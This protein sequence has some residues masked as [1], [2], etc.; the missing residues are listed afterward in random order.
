MTAEIITIGDE[1]LIGQIVDTN[2]A[3]ISEK[4][5]AIGVRVGEI[6]SVSDNRAHILDTLKQASLRADILILTGGLGPTKDDITKHILA[7][8]TGAKDWVL[9]QPSL[10]VVEEIITRRGLPMN[11]LNRWQAMLPD[12]CEALLNRLGTA[13]GMWFNYHGKVIVSMPGVPFEMQYIMQE[14]VEKLKSVFQLPPIYHKT[15]T[16][17]GIP[18]SLL[19]ERLASW[20]EKLPPH[21]K[22]AYLPNPQ[23]GVRLRFSV[24]EPDSETENEVA[25]QIE[26]LQTLLAN[27]I[28]GEGTDTLEIVLSRLLKEKNATLATAES[29]T[30]GKIASMI[31]SVSGS[32]AYFRGGIIAYDNE[33]KINILGVGKTIIEKYGAV[34]LEVVE[35]M[36]L[37][38]RK[39]LCSDYAIATSG[40]AGPNGGTPQKPV[41]L[42]CIAVATP[43]GVISEQVNFTGNRPQIIERSAACALNLL[44]LELLK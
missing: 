25:R 10:A 40:I 36:A 30:G 32:S 41:G 13:P 19:A 24:Y 7:E 15:I 26:K 11:E 37:G 5:N 23:T 18:E 31:T 1:I 12:T 33:V 4:L 6:V 42:V 20:E 39:T 14:V 38:A 21:I 29:C 2:S 16:T 35:Q 44:R 22:L 3:Y 9:H 34:S 28:Y 8:F 17:Y 43:R 27:A